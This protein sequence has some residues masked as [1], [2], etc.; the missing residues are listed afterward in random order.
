LTCPDEYIAAI[1]HLLEV[2]KYEIQCPTSSPSSSKRTDVVPLVINTQ[3]W[4][5]GLGEDLLRG[6][7]AAASPTHVF[8][9]DYPPLDND[10]IFPNSPVFNP[11][12]LPPDQGGP[13]E[14]ARVFVL[15]PAPVSPL[16]AR[17]TSADMRIL[18]LI[19]YLHSGL[20][21]A[22]PY[23]D[24]TVPLGAHQPVEV[25]VG[26][27][28]PLKEIYLLGEGS[29][30][31][32]EDDLELA[33]NGAIVALGHNELPPQDVYSPARQLPPHD[34]FNIL[35]LA[36]IRGIR[37]TSSGFTLHLVTPLKADK[38]V[39]VNCIVHNGAIELPLCGLLDWREEGGKGEKV[40]GAVVESGEAP[41]LDSGRAG[42]V[43]VERRRIRRNLQRRNV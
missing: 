37:R 3:G 5:K 23:W 1:R 14:S 24:F 12:L 21:A 22:L 40:F 39:G 18:S 13:S 32:L 10:D 6:I 16:Q 19:T 11:A 7:E 26:V 41:F 4:V 35:G 28:G 42:G 34:D 9:F 43:G 20:P 15:E 30:G 31:I 17:Y 27:D 25:N 2:Y 36:L 38:L 8:A 29:E 33:L